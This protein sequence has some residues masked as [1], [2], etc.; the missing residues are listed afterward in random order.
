MLRALLLGCLAASPREGKSSESLT[1]MPVVGKRRGGGTRRR[2]WTGESSGYLSAGEGPGP[3]LM[4]LSR[5]VTE[6]TFSA[7]LSVLW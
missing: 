1:L 6:L 2:R 4:R 3:L 7:M 5:G